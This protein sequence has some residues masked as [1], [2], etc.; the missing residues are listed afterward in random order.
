MRRLTAARRFIRYEYRY[1]AV[2]QTYG[3]WTT[4]SG[5][6]SARSLTVTGLTNGTEYGFQVRAVNGI[7]EGPASEDSATPGRAPSMPTGLTAGA[8]SETIT[9]MWGDAG[10]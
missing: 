7:G 6:G 3:E 9:V 5:G 1:G 8:E 10:R 2:G 4:V